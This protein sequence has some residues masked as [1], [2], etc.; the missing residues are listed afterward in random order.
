MTTKTFYPRTVTQTANNN[1]RK[2]KDL[3][4]IKATGNGY[5][6]SNGNIKSK[7]SSPNR[8]AIIDCSD[9]NCN[10]PV[11]ATITKITVEYRHTKHGASNKNSCNIPAPTIS[12]LNGSTVIKTNAT[13]PG[14]A[15]AQSF[16]FS[17]KGKAPT[18]VV[19]TDPLPVTFNGSASMTVNNKKVTE[20]Y[21]LPSRNIVNNKNFT[22]RLNYP[23]NTNTY[24]GTLRIYW[25]RIKVEYVESKFSLSMSKVES[26]VVGVKQDGYNHE[27]YHLKVSVSRTSKTSYIPKVTIVSPSGFSFKGA[28]SIVI[29]KDTIKQVSTHVIEY[30][31][32]LSE[33]IGV[34][35][36]SI[37]LVFD[38]DVS[39]AS[40]ETSADFT[41]ECSENLNNASAS[42]T[43]H[44]TDRP[45][46]ATT[47]DEDTSDVIVVDTDGNVNTSGNYN[48][49]G[50]SL[51]RGVTGVIYLELSDEQ[52][53]H[54]HQSQAISN[55]NYTVLDST[56]VDRTNWFTITPTSYNKTGSPIIVKI[57]PKSSCSDGV[58]NV[59]AHITVMT[60]GDDILG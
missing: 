2:F 25:V 40:G 54:M 51:S 42:H 59:S 18:M 4:V 38:V 55:I 43:A 26:I 39:Y 11:G 22:V 57:T 8:P 50:L 19:P 41:F 10:I 36:D 5:A 35:G 27:E 56:G 46:A 12:L 20:K 24:E 29:R 17:K 48:F 9:F 37:E 31:P 1:Q 34:S 15:H 23:T 6:E 32:E 49:D 53:E 33:K 30:T 3:N 7:K 21:E 13:V 47:D 44:I 60:S 52:L 16:T 14:V 28:T 58:F 45:V